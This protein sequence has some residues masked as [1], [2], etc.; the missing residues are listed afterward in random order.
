[1]KKEPS[2]KQK[3]Q[4]WEKVY[5]RSGHVLVALGFLS[6]TWGL[7]L[8]T[9]GNM[10]QGTLFFFFAPLFLIAST[11]FFYVFTEPTDLKNYLVALYDERNRTIRK[12]T[13]VYCFYVIINLFIAL[14][15]FFPQLTIRDLVSYKLP[16]ILA[17]LYLF[18]RHWVSK[19]M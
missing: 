3:C 4:Y 2:L 19:K 12:Q 8:M 6:A 18:L 16:L 14:Y 7:W 15:F 13:Q 1:M 17:Y 10:R 9:R 11:F 5:T